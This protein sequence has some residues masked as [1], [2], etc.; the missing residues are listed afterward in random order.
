MLL[1]EHSVV[2][3]YPAL[4]CAVDQVIEI[5]WSKT[6]DVTKSEV[7]ER[8]NER[9]NEPNNESTNKTT[10]CI[11]SALANFQFT[12]AE[13]KAFKQHPQLDHPQLRFV[14]HALNAFA[15]NLH[16]GL[17]I[18]INSEFSSTI[19]LG[20]SAAVLAATLHGLNTITQQNLSNLELFH[21]G[22]EIILKIQGR[23][24]GTDLAAS[25]T[26]GIVLFEPA[27][28]GRPA[29]IQKLPESISQNFPLSLVYCGYKTP[30]AEV[31]K[32]VANHWQDQP[33][34]LN[35]LYALMGE[36]TKQAY[37]A[38]LNG[39]LEHLYALSEIYQ[40]FMDTL[41]VNDDTLQTI[42]KQMRACSSIGASKISGSGLGDCVLGLGN[43][44][45]CPKSSQS[46][47]KNYTQIA[48]K[49]TSTGAKT[50]QA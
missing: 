35:K 10:I 46:M 16:H 49:T 22:H 39:K 29:N 24:S 45:D 18:E 20:S 44:S 15:P 3:G 43:L 32:M 30:T 7:D 28:Q 1:G 34:E 40:D 23:G 12:L 31:L 21:I 33:E 26:G 36:T 47:L 25:L 42:I 41:G 38:V 48:I 4:A 8:T 13:L 11:E 19:G 37:Q 50:E 17:H 9:T 27:I 6:D 2:Y 14:M 5:H